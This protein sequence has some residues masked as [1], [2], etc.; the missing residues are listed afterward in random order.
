M[1]A[2]AQKSDWSS[3]LLPIEAG[4]VWF[5][6]NFDLTKRNYLW[7]PVFKFCVNINGCLKVS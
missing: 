5:V 3:F 7:R 6:S 1:Q 2:S 4:L